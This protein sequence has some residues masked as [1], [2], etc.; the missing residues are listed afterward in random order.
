MIAPHPPHPPT[1]P[2]RDRYYDAYENR[3]VTHPPPPTTTTT[4]PAI[5]E[6]DY[7]RTE[8]KA[9]QSIFSKVRSLF[10]PFYV[11]VSFYTHENI[12]RPRI[13]CCFQ[14]V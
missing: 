9:I 7:V 1:P 6:R 11:T 4:R 8:G 5:Y 2:T 14:G 12:I 13:F 3:Y 10:N